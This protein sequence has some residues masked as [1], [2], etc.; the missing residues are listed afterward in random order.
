MCVRPL[1]NRDL[2]LFAALLLVL[3]VPALLYIGIS[4]PDKINERG[5]LE[6]EYGRGIGLPEKGSTRV[7]NYSFTF[8]TNG[9]EHV[10]YLAP[11]EVKEV[12]LVINNTGDNNDSYFVEVQDHERS[13]PHT[14]HDSISSTMMPQE[15]FRTTLNVTAPEDLFSHPREYAFEIETTSLSQ[16]ELKGNI[17]I[18]FILSPIEVNMEM[19]INNG[20][21]EPVTKLEIEENGN[22]LLYLELNNIGNILDIYDVKLSGLSQ[23]WEAFFR[24]GVRELSVELSPVGNLSTL[25]EILVI[26]CEKNSTENSPLV[27][28]AN[29]TVSGSILGQSLSRVITI[30]L[31]KHHKTNPVILDLREKYYLVGPDEYVNVPLLA[32]N[33]GPN[34]ISFKPFINNSL[35][36]WIEVVES[37]SL[38]NIIPEETTA[39]YRYKF[40]VRPNAPVESELLI[41]FSGSTR[42][43][44]GQVFDAW[45]HMRVEQIFNLTAT[46]DN[47]TLLLSDDIHE[48]IELTLTN[49]GNGRE[50]VNIYPIWDDYYEVIIS[51]KKVSLG[52][53]ESQNISIGI[54]VADPSNGTS[55]TGIFHVVSLKDSFIFEINVTIGQEP[56][57]NYVDLTLDDMELSLSETKYAAEDYRYLNFTVV[58]RGNDDSGPFN[59]RVRTKNQL[60]GI[61]QSLLD[62][63]ENN[64][65]PGD[66]LFFSIPLITKKADWKIV[67]EIDSDLE[68]DETSEANNIFES[69]I[70]VDNIEPETSFRSTTGGSIVPVPVYIGGGGILLLTVLFSF[71]YALG[72]ESLKYSMLGL[73]VPLYSKLSHDDILTH[74]T[75]ERVYRFVKSH[76]GEHYRSILLSLGLKNGTLT[77]HL[78]TLEK[79][80]F[81]TSEKDG[82]YRRFFP[83]GSRIGRKIFINGLRK[84]IYDFLLRNPGLSQKD[85]SQLLECSPPTVN[86]HINN[87]VNQDLVKTTRKGRETHCFAINS[88]KVN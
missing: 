8:A 17:S 53:F 85:I 87:L 29:S 66:T 75:R 31:E 34:G 63:K 78:S 40:H 5:S 21:G 45:I 6:N 30:N 27:I 84:E 36:E 70:Y 56:I 86:Y 24:T 52:P 79:R 10:F 73:I 22:V 39:E 46:I 57:H 82:P 71:V 13:W 15:E 9:S 77:Y 80:E 32:T 23:G 38:Y 7:S 41:T 64:M 83:S 88:Q 14:L 76:P 33:F 3:A 58:N 43:Q 67:V 60:D 42:E 48:R 69:N 51:E 47:M 44:H 68:V 11:G 54:S 12:V 55:G 2:S 1:T 61:S 49:N 81:I 35:P 74:S 4:I 18:F 26:R 72:G 16:P 20:L 28:M 59:I 50:E 19:K 37:P 62:K 65:A 25:D